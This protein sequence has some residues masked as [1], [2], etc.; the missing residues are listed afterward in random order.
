[1]PLGK[2][3]SNMGIVNPETIKAVIANK[4]GIPF[5]NLR[6]FSVAPE[7][8]SRISAGMAIRYR[9]VPVCVSEGALVVATEN[10]VGMSIWMSCASSRG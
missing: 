1:M 10:P 2:V 6:Q 9:I 8:L 7:V 5:V 4:M 3:L